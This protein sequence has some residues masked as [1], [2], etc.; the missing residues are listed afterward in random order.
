M[1]RVHQALGIA[2][3]SPIAGLTTRATLLAG[4]A[5]RADDIDAARA[6]A[7][8]AELQSRLD[9]LRG[10]DAA[11]DVNDQCEPSPAY[12]ET[13]LLADDNYIHRGVVNLKE[14]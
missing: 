6:E 13:V 10:D 11:A 8:R 1:P 2:G 12:R 14:L 5:E 9:Q 7:A 3:E 4:V